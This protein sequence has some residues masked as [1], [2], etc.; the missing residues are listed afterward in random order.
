[1]SLP[2]PVEL[3]PSLIVLA[4]RAEQSLQAAL[5]AHEGL[6][7]LLYTSRCV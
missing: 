7:C 4:E 3:P 1:M 6:V 2:L 5:V